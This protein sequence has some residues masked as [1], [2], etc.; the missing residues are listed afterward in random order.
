MLR[1][2][3]ALSRTSGLKPPESHQSQWQ[4]MKISIITAVYNREATVARAIRSIQTQTYPDVEHIVIDG[5]SSDR[6]RDVVQACASPLVKLIS[7]PDEGIYDAINKGIRLAKGDVL[8]LVHSDDRFARDDV[9]DTVASC[10]ADDSLDAVYA[11]VAFFS[12]NSPDRLV[13]RFNSGRFRPD[14]IPMGWMPAHTALFLRRRVFEKFGFYKTDYRIAAD[15]E[16]VAR[17]FK[18]G[19]IRARY[20]PEVWVHMQTG[21]AST[22]GL[23]S[24][25][26]LNREVLRALRENGIRSNYFKILSKYPWKLLEYVTPEGKP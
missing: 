25:I 20:V 6:T 11:D 22:A 1:V 26:T 13:R 15:F 4:R 3:N 18:D 12:S 21:G 7:E 23:S 8:G 24:K 9:L 5:E 16:F 14:R 17:I 10:F 2:R 19:G